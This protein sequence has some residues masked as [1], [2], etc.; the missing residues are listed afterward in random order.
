MPLSAARALLDSH[1]T[2]LD[3]VKGRIIEH[4]AVSRLLGPA[5]RGQGRSPVLCLIGEC[6]RGRRGWVLSNSLALNTKE[7]PSHR[8]GGGGGTRGWG[9]QGL[10]QARG[11]G[12]CATF[13]CTSARQL[14]DRAGVTGR[15]IEHSAVS[16][17]L[18]LQTESRGGHLCRA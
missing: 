5:N 7:V 10:R 16:R 12:D 3:K 8:R 13:C 15:V 17:L 6:G 2:G 9:R 18:A 11:G 4:L 14:P 1:H